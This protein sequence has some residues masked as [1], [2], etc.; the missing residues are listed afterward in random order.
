MAV[1]HAGPGVTHHLSDPFP[2]NRF[3][4]V[5]RAFGA[6][7]LALLKRTSFEASASVLHKRRTIPAQLFRTVMLA[8]IH[9]YHGCDGVAFPC[10]AGM[11][12]LHTGY[13]IY[14]AV[15]DV[16]W[17]A[18]TDHTPMSSSGLTG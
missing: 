5:Y 10:D 12:N 7:G 13:I 16:G 8:A 18:P 11:F 14:E 2:H 9:H 17:A 3:E 4:A 6:G 1:Y 15:P